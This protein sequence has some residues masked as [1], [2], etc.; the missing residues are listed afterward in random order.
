M[1][2]PPLPPGGTIPELAQKKGVHH[3]MWL[4]FTMVHAQNK[5]KLMNEIREIGKNGHFCTVLT[6][7]L[8]LEWPQVKISK[9]CPMIFLHL[10]R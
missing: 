8:P 1:S 10:G 9:I 3:I 2:S 5:K 4:I 6:T 7:P